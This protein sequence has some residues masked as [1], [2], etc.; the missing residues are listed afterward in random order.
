[1]S[2]D[3]QRILDTLQLIGHAILATLEILESKGL[4]KPDSY[5]K[6]ISLV[7]GLLVEVVM[8][9]P[10]GYDEPEFSWVKAMISKAKENGIVVAG[11]PFGVEDKVKKFEELEYY[12][13]DSE[14]EDD[15][16]GD[17]NADQA[18]TSGLLKSDWEGEVRHHQ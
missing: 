17:E 9:W 2:D 3:S 16:N 15:E 13:D 11:A 18:K 5:V 4:L 10:S 1:M 8:V 7:L 12:D 6:D 14:D